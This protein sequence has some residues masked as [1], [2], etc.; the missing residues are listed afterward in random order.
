MNLLEIKEQNLL[1]EYREEIIRACD[2]SQ[3]ALARKLGVKPS[4]IS[5]VLK[6]GKFTPLRSLYQ[7]IKEGEQNV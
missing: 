4:Y 2:P 5:K 6:E 3:S 7:K 1:S